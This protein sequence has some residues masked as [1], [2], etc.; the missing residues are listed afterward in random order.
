G[1]TALLLTGLCIKD[2]IADVVT[3][4]YDR[5]LTYDM[6]VSFRNAPTDAQREE[7]TE[8]TQGMLESS[9]Y[10]MQTSVDIS[11]NRITKS[12]DLVVPEDA[13]QITEVLRLFDEKGEAIAYPGVGEAVISAKCA[14]KLGLQIGDT[15]TLR[16]GDMRELHVKISGICTNYVYNYVYLCAE[17]YFSQLGS[18]PEYKSMWCNVAEGR[19]VHEVGAKI[20]SEENTAS[21]NI[22]EDMKQRFTSMMSSLNYIV[23]LV[24]F[25]AAALAFIVLYNL[26]NINITERIREIATIKVLGFYPM[27]TAAY[28][29]RENLV[30]TGMGA[31][32]GIP[33]GIW[34]HR[35]VMDKIDIDMVN[36]QVRIL[37]RSFVFGIVLTFVFAMLV[38]GVMYLK[39]QRIN[40]AESL[41]SIE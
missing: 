20:M 37:P 5:I 15:V 4:Q 3:E 41:K 24:T 23:V 18:E 21:A 29:F 17:T 38:N 25:C 12:I 22:T 10:Y 34:L 16:D 33:I 32:V 27:E 30:L 26:T 31:I 36:F 19:D 11:F 2:S 1:G 8:D 28:V 40:M 35:F 7:F 6:A 9:I 14:Q 39:L 13:G